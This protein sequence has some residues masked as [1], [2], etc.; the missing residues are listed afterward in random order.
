MFAQKEGETRAVSPDGAQPRPNGAVTAT[1]TSTAVLT[2]HRKEGL[3]S[4][5]VGVHK[6]CQAI[7][8]DCMGAGLVADGS[9]GG[10]P[11]G[12]KGICM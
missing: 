2:A 12:F 8:V 4:G 10:H 3:R 6:P 7:H 5:R 1:Y 11:R 9:M